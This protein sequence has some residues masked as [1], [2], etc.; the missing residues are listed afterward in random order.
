MVKSFLVITSL[1]RSFLLQLVGSCVNFPDGNQDNI[2]ELSTLAKRHNIGLHVD[3]CLGSF[4]VPFLEAAGLSTGDKN[5]RYRLS[6]FDFSVNGVTSISCDTHKVCSSTLLH[7]K[8][9]ILFIL[10]QYGFAPKVGFCKENNVLVFKK[11]QGTSVIMY[12]TTELRSYQYYVNSTWC[13]MLK[14]DKFDMLL[15][16]S[17][18]TGGVYASPSMSGSR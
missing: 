13:G 4:I 8:D 10:K 5:G 14:S 3:C 6:P 17:Y 16:C 7:C 18:H 2:E 1:P 12:R 11:M 15:N 9:A